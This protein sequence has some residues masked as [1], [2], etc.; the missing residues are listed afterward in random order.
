LGYNKVVE[1]IPIAAPALTA[2]ILT[3]NKIEKIE[4]FTGH[5]K[6]K[7]LDLRRNKVGPL[8]GLSNM[9]ELK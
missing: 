2:L 6:L 5:P 3:E 1:L 4:T 8:Q 7:K 9:P